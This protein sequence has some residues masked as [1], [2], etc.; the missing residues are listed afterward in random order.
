[1][2]TPAP[3]PSPPIVPGLRTGA[4]WAGRRVGLLGG[5][6]NPAHEGHRHASLEAIRRLGLNEVWWLVSP[7]NPLKPAAGMAD[8]ATRLATARARAR[9]PRIRVT[10]LEGDLGTRYTVET[11]A[12][13]RRRYPRTHFVWLMGADNLAQIPRWRG[14]VRIFGMVPVAVMPRAPYSLRALVGK[15]AARFAGSR[16]APGRARGL[17]EM[18]PP[19]WTFLEG[20][21]HP[22]SATEIRRG[23]DRRA[24]VP[25]TPKPR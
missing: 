25:A 3:P 14:W 2:S 8:L 22:A 5:S 17:A 7:Q 6:F 12:E 23:G 18:P 4:A 13:L 16:V 11:L 20:P 15:A 9:H 19:A 21:V 24:W 10:A 1:M